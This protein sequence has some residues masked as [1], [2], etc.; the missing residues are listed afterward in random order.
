MKTRLQ[1][2]DEALSV[3]L[4]DDGLITRA[5]TDLAHEEIR[6]KGGEWLPVERFP[7]RVA[8]GAGPARQRPQAPSRPG[9]FRRPK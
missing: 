2:N 4:V 7:G 1:L 8:N 3:S 9:E 6:E 5:A